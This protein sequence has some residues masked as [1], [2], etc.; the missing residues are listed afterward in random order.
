MRLRLAYLL[1]VH[2]EGGR[3]LNSNVELIY[4]SRETYFH[5]DLVGLTVHETFKKIFRLDVEKN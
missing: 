2:Q 1:A 3:T 5:F 4:I